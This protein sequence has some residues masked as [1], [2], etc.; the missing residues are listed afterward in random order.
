MQVRIRKLITGRTPLALLATTQILLTTPTPVFAQRGDTE[1]LPTVRIDYA[2]LDLTQ[3]EGRKILRKRI[4]HGAES[5]CGAL[6]HHDSALELQYHA[7]VAGTLRDAW[8]KVNPPNT[9]LSHEL[10]R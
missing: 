9:M 1:P 5:V 10:P 7:C 4:L 6:Y 3:P 8:S 2:D